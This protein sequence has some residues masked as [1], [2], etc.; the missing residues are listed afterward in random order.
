MNAILLIEIIILIILWVMNRKKL[1]TAINDLKQQLTDNE[2]ER[3][4]LSE[5]IAELKQNCNVLSSQI[6]DLEQ[7]NAA[8]NK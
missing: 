2:N 1:K 5:Q 8:I 3:N 6:L 7:N 4:N